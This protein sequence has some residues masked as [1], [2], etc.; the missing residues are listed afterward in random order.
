MITWNDLPEGITYVG[1][2]SR[3]VYLLSS[4]MAIG[5]IIADYNSFK[6]E[7]GVDIPQNILLLFV[8]RLIAS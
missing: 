3:T 5:G 8:S 4:G 7:I 6:F 2:E 1:V